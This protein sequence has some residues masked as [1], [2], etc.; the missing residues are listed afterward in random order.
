M[1]KSKMNCVY[2]MNAACIF[3]YKSALI[4]TSFKEFNNIHRNMI[5]L[6]EYRISFST[7]GVFMEIPQFMIETN[8]I[9]DLKST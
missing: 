7:L 3:I 5:N 1:S 9:N 8:I 2:I 4:R 6:H